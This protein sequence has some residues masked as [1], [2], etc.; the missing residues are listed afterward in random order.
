MSQAIGDYAPGVKVIANGHMYTPRY[1]RKI[2]RGG[3]Y[4]FDCG[5]IQQCPNCGTLNYQSIEP[6]K[7]TKC[8]G[9]GE[10][11][12]DKWT[13]A[14][15][16]TN[17]LYTDGKLEEVPLD[18]PKKLYHS[19]AN[20]VGKDVLYHTYKY[21]VGK[22]Q[23]IVYSSERDKIA[24]TSE[25]DSPFYVC[26]RCGY[27][28]GKYDSALDENFKTDKK[29][30]GKLQIGN[31][32]TVSCYHKETDGAKCSNHILKKRHLIHEFNTDI[33]QIFFSKKYISHDESTTLS[34]LTAL[35][36]ATARV[37]HIERNDISGCVRFNKG[38][39]NTDIRF[40][41]FDNVP[42]GAGHVKR[43]LNG[44][45]ETMRLIITDAYNYLSRCNCNPSCYKCLRSYENQEFHDKLDRFKAI[46]FF[47]DYIGS[48][49]VPL[50]PGEEQKP[51]IELGE[52][53]YGDFKS[54]DDAFAYDSRTSSRINEFKGSAYPTPDGYY[55]PLNGYP[56]SYLFFVWKK[57][58][59]LLIDKDYLKDGAKDALDADDS[60]TKIDITDNQWSDKLK[61]ALIK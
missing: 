40:I 23:I 21:S 59:V 57:E 15:Q 58:K 48:P 19:H 46:D 13:E 14:I 3:K 17:G 11:L 55:V 1:I 28:V 38:E 54:I 42:G 37:L 6:P 33:I 41:L 16:P 25:L 26:D 45:G 52:I 61:S 4:D 36:D 50:K 24:V 43:I 29:E 56:D 10:A 20:Y 47:K 34:V 49:F 5:Y 27:S 44:D 35:L 39:E 51:T 53:S 8:V 60:W 9:C 18:K 32:K 12:P 31:C 7:D 2:S 30:T 22:N